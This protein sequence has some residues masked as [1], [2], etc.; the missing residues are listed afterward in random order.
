MMQDGFTSGLAP[1]APLSELPLSELQFSLTVDELKSDPVRSELLIDLLRE[2]NLTYDQR[3]TAATIR[4]RG[5]VLLALGHR[6]LSETALLFIFEELDNGRDAYLVAAAARSLRSYAQAAPAMAPF[7]VRAIA[8]V[9]FHD[10]FV[11]LERYGGYAISQRDTAASTTAVD[12]L[13]AAL[14]W[15]GSGARDAAPAIEALLA[16]NVKGGGALSQAQSGELRA[17]LESL[18]GAEVLG[19][20]R[21][22]CCA[23]PSAIGALREWLPGLRPDKKEIGSVVF[24]DHDGKRITFQ[25][26][27]HGCPSV[28]AFFYSRCTNPFKCSLTVAKLARLQ[29]LLID[30]HLDGRIR[31]AAITYDPDFDLAERLRGYGASRG[32]RMDTDNRLLRT[33]EGIEPVR[34]YFRLGVNFIESLVN[35]HRVEVYI[36]DA[37]GGIAASFERIQWDENEVLDRA[38]ALLDQVNRHTARADVGGKEFAAQNRGAGTDAPVPPAVAPAARQAGDAKDPVIGSALPAA[39]SALA[40]AAAFF[41]KCPVCWAAYLSVFGIA[42]L[43]QMPYSP[44]LL[45]L[46]ACL[47][48]VNLGS[49]WLRHRARERMTGFYIAATGALTILIPGLIFELEYASLGGV[50]LT[51]IGSLLGVFSWSGNLNSRIRSS[52]A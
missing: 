3:G 15:L 46:F 39:L 23:L 25:E 17:I 37:A 11:C 44:W 12:E 8:N 33:V 18:R 2:D 43:E 51:V 24:E 32:V 45:P 48:L 4:M 19:E 22:A 42:G 28:V 26:F 16:D 21:L 20:P 10:D 49:L 27:F 41:P 52:A 36:L 47:M 35:R 13:F 30:R 5:W 9:Q 1:E 7:L 40:L 31:T 50:V 29:K 34:K 14:R 38:A 6:R